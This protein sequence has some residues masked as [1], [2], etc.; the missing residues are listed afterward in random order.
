MQSKRR[1]N[2]K[3]T[4]QIKLCNQEEKTTSKN[5]EGKIHMQNNKDKTMNLRRKNNQQKISREK[6]KCKTTRKKQPMQCNAI[7]CN[8][9][10]QREK[11]PKKHCHRHNGPRHCFYNLTHLSSYKG[12]KFSRKE[13]STLYWF[14]F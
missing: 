4:T 7:Q 6:F 1:K 13:N 11:T 9:K 10:K 14:Q 2:N 8:A 3:K 5:I 12:G